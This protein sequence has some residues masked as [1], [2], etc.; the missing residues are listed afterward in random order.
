MII[1]QSS[2]PLTGIVHTQISPSGSLVLTQTSNGFQLVTIGQH[3]T[4]TMAGQFA[5]TGTIRA[6]TFSKDEQYVFV[7]NDQGNI[8]VIDIHD[9]ENPKSIGFVTTGSSVQSLAISGDGTQLLVGTNTGI[10]CFSAK[11]PATLNTMTVVT[12]YA[13]IN[14]VTTIQT[15]PNTNTVAIGSGNNVTMLD[16]TNS[17]FTQLSQTTFGSPVK[18]IAPSDQTDPTQLAVTLNNRDTVLM[19]I[20]NPQSVVV[21]STISAT[22][23]TELTTV[24]SGTLLV[25]GVEPGIQIFD[26][27]REVGYSPVTNNVTSLSFASN[28]KFAVYSDSEGLK[29]IEVIQDPGRLDVPLP[30]LLNVVQLGFPISC[31]L[32]N[33]A[34]NWIAVGGNRLTFISRDNLQLPTVLGTLNT[35]GNVQQMVFFPDKTKLLLVDDGGVACVDCFNPQAPRMLGRWNSGKP[36]YGLT[37]GGINAYVCQGEAGISVLDVTNPLN[38]VNKATLSTQ[39]S[40]LSILFNRAQTRAYTAESSGINNWQVLTPLKFQSVGR[41]NSTGSNSNMALSSDENTLFVSEGQLL[42]ELDVSD[43][44]TPNLVNELDATYPIKDIRLSSQ[45]PAAYLAVE[46]NGMIIVNT[47]TMQIAGSL[48]GTSANSMVLSAS[49]DQILVA[50]GDDGLQVAALVTELPIIPFTAITSYPVGI[51][52]EETLLFVDQTRK[53]IKVNR[54]NSIQYINNGQRQDLPEWISADLI[55]QKLFVT[56][57]AELT[58]LPIQLVLS[59]DVNGVTEDTIYQAQV[60]SSLEISSDKGPVSIT[61]P[62]PTVSVSV[63]LTQGSFI[64]LAPGPLSVSIENNILQAFGPLPIVN[65][66]LGEVRVMPNPSNLA[67]SEVALSPAEISAVDLVNQNPSNMVV[68]LR[69]FRFNQP[70]VVTNPMN[71]TNIKALDPFEVTVPTDCF[72]DPDDPT[73][74]LSAQQLGGTALPSGITFINGVF[75]GVVPAKDLNTTFYIEINGTDGYY[76]ASTIWELHINADRGPFVAKPIPSITCTTSSECSWGIPDGTFVDPDNNSYTLTAVQTGYDVLP[77]FLN[78]D[79]DTFL[80]RP[81]TGDVGE[82]GIEVTGTDVFNKSAKTTFDIQVKYS[83]W[84]FFLTVLQDLGIVTAVTTPLTT[85]Y[86]YRAFIYN[87]VKRGTYWRNE[88]PADFLQGKGYKPKHPITEKEIEKDKIAKIRVMA[89]DKESRGHDCARGKLPIYCYVTLYG[90]PLLNDEPLPTWL[91]LDPDAG[92]L[93][94]KPEHFSH[95]NKSYVF[96][97]LGENGFILES[98]FIDP[99]KISSY[100][101]PVNLTEIV[102]TEHQATPLNLRDMVS[103]DAES[104]ELMPKKMMSPE[105]GLN[106][107]LADLELAVLSNQRPGDSEA[108]APRADTQSVADA[109]TPV[110]RKHASFDM[111]H[112]LDHDEDGAATAESSHHEGPNNDGLTTEQRRQKSF[113]SD[114]AKKLEKALSK[115]R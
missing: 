77:G 92:T 107:F 70:P 79:G 61:T 25:A 1:Q 4:M 7:A 78:F 27:G 106:D 80:A 38:M 114:E 58:G 12:S 67:D 111:T 100:Q 101:A 59:I 14:P 33:E 6:T 17:Q 36:I 97:V 23:S 86:I 24:S 82:V 76:T 37:L 73:L 102:S 55:Q 41:F 15:N 52:V 63:N 88:I 96:Q 10:Q 50:D 45:G 85:L 75:G 64:P 62:S 44:S 8:Q 87:N 84:D 40:A 54:I 42:L 47:E 112:L 98:F 3:D 108:A 56:A 19:D 21:T 74:L 115:K 49:E 69:S 22:S 30:E 16:F 9:P 51:A 46:I 28:G 95:G 99:D 71:R 39:G 105:A 26:A 72:T 93:V 2:L 104:V 81:G 103:P 66:Y 48:P 34:N 68:Q 90:K 20:T 113:I 32:L 89:L 60:V 35:T 109:A 43:P 5:T 65:Q 110:R 29:L 94:L 18:A 13:T 83:S 91:D 53:P 11:T 31:V 57:P